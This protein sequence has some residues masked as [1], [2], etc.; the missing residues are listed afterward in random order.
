[1]AETHEFQSDIAKLL[2]L[3]SQSL[4]QNREVAVRELVSNASDALDKYRL[5]SLRE[6]DVP[7]ADDLQIVVTPDAE[8]KTLTI[9][10]NGVGM[11]HDD[12]IE[13]LGTIAHSGTEGFSQGLEG[14]DADS[15]IGQFGVGFYAAFM[16]AESVEVRTR[17][18]REEGGWKWTSAGTG[19]FEIDQIAMPEHGTEVVLHL[20]DD[21]KD[22][23]DPQRVEYVL[24]R[25]SSFVPH[26][27]RL[28]GL[29]SDGEPG[30]TLHVNDQP[31]I[32]VEPKGSVTPEQH[33]Q[34]FG[35]LS[36][37]VGANPLWNLHLSLDSPLEI[38]SILYCPPMNPE[39]M[40]LGRAE[41]GL[42]LC[43]RRVLVQSDCD[44]LLPEYLR[45]L[46]GL[47][48]SSDLPLNVSRQALQDDTVFRKIRQV[49]TGKVLSRLS[50]LAE[51]EPKTYQ[52][53]YEQFGTTL[54]EGVA[55]DN[56]NR[57]KIAE[58]LRFRTIDAPDEMSGLKAYVEGMKEGQTQI[59]HVGGRDAEAVK[60]RPTLEAFTARG[61][62]V[63]LLTDPVDE[64]VLSTLDEYDGK[65]FVSVESAE[66]D[67]PPLP[68][69]DDEKDDRPEP[70]APAGL[71]AVL[72]LFREALGDETEEIRQTD[73]L[74]GS[75]CRLV[76]PGG[77]LSPQLQSVLGANDKN[78]KPP[79]RILEV[80]PRHPLVRRLA[81]LSVNAQNGDFIKSCGRQLFDNALLMSGMVPDPTELAAR[82][83]R[84]MTD[85]AGAKSSVI[86]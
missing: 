14:N 22:F 66:A 68:E 36:G 55:T 72:G 48:D 37:Q 26:P 8:A 67:L 11:T 64:I 35:Y 82:A 53:F 76:T 61:L 54:R 28:A 18:Y 75:P 71:E 24:K 13:N 49:L 30:E 50:K 51:N 3:L 7:T 80:N 29:S 47:V 69:S 27:I 40:G 42:H 17:S 46:Y 78:F 12:L 1:M 39:L 6:E 86:L 5:L 23:A 58:L 9:A 52:E 10:D 19:S 73:K 59:F 25:Y 34:F 4:Y 74:T 43:A 45:F 31:P 84:F 77:G 2:R 21:A 62:N 33:R 32:W 83:E 41:H 20:R 70:A 15:L 16:L 56:V 57:D 44:K 81:D 63:L 60:R 79:K 85:A 38:K 65:K